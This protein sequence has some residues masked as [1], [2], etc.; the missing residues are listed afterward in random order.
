MTTCAVYARVSTDEQAEKYGLTAQQHELRAHAAAKGYRVVDEFLDD[1]HSG[2]TLDRPALMRLRDAV[3]AGTIEVVLAH[4]PD[5]LS[6]KLAHQLLLLEEL[7]ARCRVE[8]LTTARTATPEGGLLLNVKAVVAE[9]ERLKIVERT[10]RGKR[11]KA[12]R[13]LVVA[14]YPYGYRPDPA[15]PGRLV[16]HEEEASVIRM[17]HAWLIEERKTTRKI[18]DELRRLGVPSSRPGRQWGPTQVLRILSSDRYTGRVYYNRDAI[19]A[20]GRRQR[21][22]SEWIAVPIPP[23]ITPEQHAAAKAALARNRAA[24]VG[25]PARFTYL[26]RGL[27]RCSAC[28]RRYDSCPN[29]GRRYYRCHGRDRFTKGPQCRSPWLSAR[30]AEA[31]VWRAVAEALRHPAVL[32]AGV[33][34]WAAQRGARDVEVRSRVEELRRKLRAVEGK[35]RKLLDL[36][37]EDGIARDEITARLRT[38]TRERDGLRDELGRAEAQVAAHDAAGGRLAAIERWATKARKGIDRLDAAGRQKVLQA[39]VDEIVVGANRSLEIRGILPTETD[40]PL[41]TLRS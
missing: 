12:R 25:R 34:N 41:S 39:L 9:Y 3:R 30:V 8:F 28:G 5:R 24:Y 31:E 11:E 36:Y 32:R 1:G 27:L 38:L 29:H 7:E 26:L 40:A 33:E 13:G 17:I 14:S 35:E 10:A 18:V 4:D 20:G 15:M 19:G 2:A 22:A 21:P 6:R 23:I 16:V 37:V